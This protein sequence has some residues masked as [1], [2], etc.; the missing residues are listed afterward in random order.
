MDAT[1][2]EHS[3]QTFVAN[4]D[5]RA[6]LYTWITENATMFKNVRTFLREFLR[7]KGESMRQDSTL[8]VVQKMMHVDSCTPVTS[9]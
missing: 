8:S 2:Y 6:N 3:F 7:V 4:C 1:K 5:Q 9:L